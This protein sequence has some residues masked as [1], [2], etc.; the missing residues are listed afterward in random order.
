VAL[1]L[2]TRGIFLERMTRL[3]DATKRLERAIARL[4]NAVNARDNDAGA[5]PAGATGDDGQLREEL[6]AARQEQSELK[7]VSREVSERLDS[8]ISRL[9]AVL[10]S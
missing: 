1:S 3:D 7:A 9:R 5:G 10:E 4:E 2:W 6:E 8:A